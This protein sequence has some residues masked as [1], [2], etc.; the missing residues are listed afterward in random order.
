VRG[1]AGAVEGPER[2]KSGRGKIY[3]TTC[4]IVDKYK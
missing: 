4:K 1:R 2:L 3:K